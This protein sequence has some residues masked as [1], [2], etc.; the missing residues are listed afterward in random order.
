MLPESAAPA[1]TWLR[2]SSTA[3]RGLVLGTVLGSSMAILD[4]SIVNVALPHIGDDLHAS[5]SGLQWTVNAYLLPLAAFVL[6]GGALGDRY[7][8]KRVFLLGVVWFAAASALCGLAPSIGLLVGARTLQGFG[9]ALLTPGSL[10]LIQSSLHPDD[11]ARAIGIW[12]G[13]GGVAGAAAAL[14]GGYIIDALNWRWIF[15]INIPLALVTI[16]VTM[17][18][19][20]ESEDDEL[21]T[22]PFDVLGAMLCALGLGALTFALVQHVLWLA[23]LGIAILGGFVWWENRFRDPMLPPRLFKSVTFSVINLVTF[24]VYGA[25][26]G[27]FFFFA[28]QLQI[29]SGY[30]AL[31]AGASTLPMT[32][33]LLVG[34]S[35]AGALG[36]RI[37]ARLPLTVGAALAAVGVAMLVRVGPD[38]NYWREVFGPVTL[39]G[40]GMTTLVA[41]L[42]ASVL[43]AVPQEFAGV[44]S[45]INNAVARSASLLAIAALPLVAGLT[46]AMYD[47]PSEFSQSYQ[48]A[49]WICA[50][51]FATGSVVSFVLL[52]RGASTTK[53]S[54][55][56]A[57]AVD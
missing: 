43:A 24:L 20:P 1:P 16:L 47:I 9:S 48:N 53:S 4:G 41:P 56:A 7:G 40:I 19:V 14:L 50:A 49:I 44:A 2:L 51:L 8:R 3:G 52:P 30:S 28:L 39:A 10:A 33:L 26:G 38:A 21:R 36:K 42:T 17:R 11:R 32:V 15:F 31:A 34:S 6:L 54:D 55:E 13:F 37:G 29:V 23:P 12:A 5:V 45:G 35:R 57:A 22:E 27:F 25:L 18:F 46:A